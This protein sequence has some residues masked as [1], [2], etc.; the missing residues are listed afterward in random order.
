MAKRKPEPIIT[1]TEILVHAIDSFERE[2]QNW[3][4]QV[5]KK[6]FLEEQVKL[7]KAPIQKKLEAL[8]TLYRIE[9]GT[10]Y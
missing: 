1:Y 5:K 2:L 7:L 3:D 9:T 8:H 10:E 6:P 4:E